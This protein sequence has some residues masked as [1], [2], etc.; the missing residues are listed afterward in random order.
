ME[1]C[2]LR[3]TIDRVSQG[4]FR[5]EEVQLV[6]DLAAFCYDEAAEFVYGIQYDNWKMAHARKAT[7]EQI[8]MY[9]LSSSIFLVSL[10][11]GA[12]ASSSVVCV[13]WFAGSL[14]RKLRMFWAEPA[15]A[16]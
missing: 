6:R 12:V 1:A 5:E 15:S 10:V 3:E 9:K 14:R 2:K 13:C 4:S 8:Y 7:A 16:G 11:L